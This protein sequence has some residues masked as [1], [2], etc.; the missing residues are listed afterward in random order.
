[1]KVAPEAATAASDDAAA[2]VDAVT[3]VQSRET[4]MDG[5]RDAVRC[6]LWVLRSRSHTR[7]WNGEKSMC[8]FGGLG[9]REEEAELVLQHSATK[10]SAFNDN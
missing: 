2:K 9:G 3:S 6:P 10:A 5:R 1:M 8:D 7:L 4:A